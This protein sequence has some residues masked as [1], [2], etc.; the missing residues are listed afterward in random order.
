ML[1]IFFQHNV[2]VTGPFYLQP[3]LIRALE[4]QCASPLERRTPDSA[5]FGKAFFFINRNGPYIG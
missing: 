2:P 4:K 3:L 5:I 1:S